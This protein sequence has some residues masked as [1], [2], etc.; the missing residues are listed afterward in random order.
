MEKYLIRLKK[1][2]NKKKRIILAVVCIFAT[3]VSVTILNLLCPRSSGGFGIISDIHA[4]RPREYRRDENSVVYPGRY[5]ICLE[6]EIAEFKS[7]GISFAIALGDNTNSYEIKYFEALKNIARQENFEIF[8]V[9]GNHDRKIFKDLGI[10]F[11]SIDR[12]PWRIIILDSPGELRSGDGQ[13]TEE[14]LDFLREKIE[15]KNKVIV[16][17]H[18]PIFN[19]ENPDEILPQYRE[20]YDIVRGKASYVLFGHWHHAFSKEL[21]G[22]KF[23][24]QEPLS[25]ENGCYSTAVKN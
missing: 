22:T 24:V 5:K 20:F 21:G 12:D 16:A 18:H 15:T 8:W 13:L 25:E 2:D 10:S 23:I 9:K 11:Y 3:F 7:N 1:I 19:I 17:M 6:S 4:G 14:Q